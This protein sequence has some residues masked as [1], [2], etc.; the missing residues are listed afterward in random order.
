MIS[1][2]FNFML[3]EESPEEND[4]RIE[5]SHRDC[6]WS[7]DL[8]EEEIMQRNQRLRNQRNQRSIYAAH[9]T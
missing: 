8:H 1:Y 4:D 9:E 6:R 7:C 3:H 2:G 5:A